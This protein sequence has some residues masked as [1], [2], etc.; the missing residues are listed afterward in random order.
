MAQQGSLFGEQLKQEGCA[1]VAFN[2][3]PLWNR[4]VD[5]CIAEC[6]LAFDEFTYDDVRR[7]AAQR[8]IPE[9]HHPNAWGARMHAAAR[10]GICRMTGR[11]RRS[12][13]G[14]AHA[15]QVEIWTR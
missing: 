1:V 13:R 14:I 12:L 2:A 9:P 5:E 11:R 6:A 3:G 8:G 10:H 15:R 4:A 7:L